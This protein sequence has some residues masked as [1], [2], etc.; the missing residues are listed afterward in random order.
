MVLVIVVDN[1]NYNE[2]SNQPF[3]EIMD[4]T[5]I[6]VLS[7]HDNN[8]VINDLNTLVVIDFLIVTLVVRYDNLVVFVIF[9]LFIFLVTHLI[10]NRIDAKVEAN[11]KVKMNYV[12]ILISI[13][14]FI[15]IIFLIF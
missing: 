12:K 3:L 4:T 10:E 14:N 7:I 5:V 1:V 15:T 13:N 11:T 8:E 2:V 6:V 9:T